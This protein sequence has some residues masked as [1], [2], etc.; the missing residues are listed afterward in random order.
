MDDLIQEREWEVRHEVNWIDVEGDDFMSEY[1]YL[2][3]PPPPPRRPALRERVA[4]DNPPLSRPPSP[5]QG[6][7]RLQNLRGKYTRAKWSDADLKLAIGALD[8]GYSM[9][10]VC[11]AFSIPK[12]SLRDHI[13]EG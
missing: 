2:P 13:M 4:A 6:T 11:E 9:R 5:P 7:Q 1:L 12:T 8:S 10:E 3:S